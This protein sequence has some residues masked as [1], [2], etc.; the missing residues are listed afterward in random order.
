MEPQQANIWRHGIR[1]GMAD[2]DLNGVVMFN[3]NRPRQRNALSR[4]LVE[5]FQQAIS[6][7]NKTAMC[8][9]LRS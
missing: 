3:L 9:I 4:R 1:F 8:V 2:Q 5:E 6:D 7:H